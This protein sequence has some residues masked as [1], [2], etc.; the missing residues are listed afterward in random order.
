MA[1][2]D[3]MDPDDAPVTRREFREEVAKL[4]T[5]D[6][7]REAVAKLATKDEL[8]E[9]VATLATKEELRA[10]VANLVTKEEL[11]E[12]LEIWA[13]ALEAR[14]ETKLGA[15]LARHTAA[16]LEA[17][18]TQIGVVDDKYKDLP[19]RVARLEDVEARRAA[20]RRRRPPQS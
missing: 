5:K 17:L 3:D 10:A 15:M 11:R 2:G 19:P 20:R 7:L 13:G 6:E 14:L 12:G 8:R 18:T 1:D 16:I 9:A 4:A